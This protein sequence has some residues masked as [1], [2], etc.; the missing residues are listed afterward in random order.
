MG[1]RVRLAIKSVDTGVEVT[2]AALVNSGYEVEEPELLVPRRLA[3]Y[4]GIPTRPPRARIE[5][6]ETPTGVFHMVL[7]PRAL[8]VHLVDVCKRVENV[9]ALVSDSEREVLISDALAS[10]LG[11]QII[12]AKKGLWRLS[13]DPP[14]TVRESCGPEYW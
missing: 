12:D 8:S 1:V 5:L 3:E 2:T 10:A 4:L 6:Y 9:H 11:I 7:A 14:D 13:S